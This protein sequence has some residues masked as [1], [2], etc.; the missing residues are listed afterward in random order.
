MREGGYLDMQIEAKDWGKDL[1]KTLEMG[2]G[3]ER[4]QLGDKSKAMSWMLGR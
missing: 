1:L 2:E 3:Q 4:I